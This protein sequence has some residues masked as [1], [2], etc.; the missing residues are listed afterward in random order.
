[1]EQKQ[2]PTHPRQKQKKDWYSKLKG[3]K[4][5]T[6]TIAKIYQFQELLK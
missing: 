1:M 4:A 3:K 2:R 6:K 5:L